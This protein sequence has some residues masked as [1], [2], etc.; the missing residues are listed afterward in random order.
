[1]CADSKSFPEVLSFPSATA[2]PAND[3][4]RWA[5]WLQVVIIYFGILAA[6]WTQEGLLKAGLMLLTTC[7][8]AIFALSSRYTAREMGLGMPPAEGSVLILSA[9]LVFALGLP[10]IASVA[11]LR[12]PPIRI[13]PWRAAWQYTVW[14]LMQQFTLQSFFYLRV[15]SLLDSRRAVLASSLLFASIHLP[16]PVLTVA[17]LFGGLF[18]CEMFRRYRTIIP[19]GIVHALL[20]L[21]IAASFSD[22]LLHHMRVGIGYLAFHP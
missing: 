17:T 14:A 5:L 1:M 3:G 10:L 21:T 22:H 18:F 8:I 2:R 7:T 9:G 20:G 19:L 15:E 16:S 4:R 13:V 12:F 11:G 6:C